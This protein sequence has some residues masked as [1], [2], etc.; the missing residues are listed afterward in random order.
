MELINMF[1]FMA[2][3]EASAS[4]RLLREGSSPEKVECGGSSVAFVKI[5]IVA[6]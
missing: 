3:P 1:S 4:R 2:Q 5:W 6:V